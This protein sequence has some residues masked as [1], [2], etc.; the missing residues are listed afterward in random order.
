SIVPRPGLSISGKVVVEGQPDIEGISPAS[1][2]F[3]GMRPDPLVTQMTPSPSTRV[4]NDGTFTLP[5]VI[6][7]RYR[8]YVPPLLNPTNPQLLSGLPPIRANLQNSYIK[9]IRVGGN[10]VLDGGVTLTPSESMTMEIVMG[11]NAAVLEGRVTRNGQP[12]SEI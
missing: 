3:I 2:L 1:G 7:G 6:A 12:A 11:A 5:G 4:S 8:V 10:D 9:S